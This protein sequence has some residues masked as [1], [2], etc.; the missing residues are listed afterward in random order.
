MRNPLKTHHLLPEGDPKCP[1]SYRISSV[2]LGYN[3]IGNRRW[4]QIAKDR[5]FPPMCARR[6]SIRQI[7]QFAVQT[8]SSVSEPPSTVLFHSD[9]A[10]FV[11]KVPSKHHR[12]FE[13]AFWCQSEGL[14][15]SARLVALV[16]LCS[17]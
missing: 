3:R 4:P 6:D 15:P 11:Y 9:N 17:I 7:F 10:P 12:V 8:G 5:R 1:K 16:R 2:K 13:V 14:P